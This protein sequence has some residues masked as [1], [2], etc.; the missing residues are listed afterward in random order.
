[1]E[2]ITITA[3]NNDSSNNKDDDDN[4]NNIAAKWSFIR[5][6]KSRYFN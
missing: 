5:T 4:N 1:M 3:N 6:I 2:T